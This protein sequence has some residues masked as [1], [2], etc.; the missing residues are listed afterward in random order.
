LSQGSAIAAAAIARDSFLIAHPWPFRP[1]S[2]TKPVRVIH[3][4][5][6]GLVHLA[7]QAALT[8]KLLNSEPH[9]ASGGHFSVL[10]LVLA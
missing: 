7:H 1:E 6:D 8:S 9:T 3:G 2:L 5:K 10:S 4:E